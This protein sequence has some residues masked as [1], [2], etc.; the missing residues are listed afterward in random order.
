VIRV[1]GSGSRQPDA[2]DEALERATHRARRLKEKLV[3]R[4]RPRHKVN[5]SKP[6]RPPA[7]DGTD[8]IGGL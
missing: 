7:P 6:E 5:G 4:S 8:E 1:H 2:F 3:H